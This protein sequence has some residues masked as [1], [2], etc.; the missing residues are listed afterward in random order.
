REFVEAA[1]ITHDAGAP[2]RWRLAG[3]PD[4]GNPS[5]LSA[6]T[7]QAWHD[8][9]LIE[10]VGEC[11]DVAELYQTAHIA[12]LP[13]YREGLPKSLIE[14][15]ACGRAIVTT[16]VPGCRDS[17]V[18]DVTGLLVPVRDAGALA[19]AVQALAQDSDKR[20]AMGRAGRAL[21]EREFGLTHIVSQQLA[22]YR[23]LS[24]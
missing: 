12:V 19:E 23:D 17:I 8:E 15:A 21:A 4:P 24:V 20:Q 7:V 13:S 1:R 22:I 5:S 14:A 6:D 9:G 18:A 10:W 16:N 11:D 3:S 2:I